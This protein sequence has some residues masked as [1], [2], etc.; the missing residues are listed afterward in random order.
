M[1]S[2]VPSNVNLL[3][4]CRSSRQGL[5]TVMTKTRDNHFVAQW[6]Q[7]GFIDAG[8]K[9]CYLTRR[10]IVRNGQNETIY[11]KKWR[12]PAQQFY[13]RDLYSTFF[14]GEVNDDIEQK[15]SGPIDDSGSKAIRAFSKNDQSQW[16]YNFE[17]FLH[18]WM[19]KNCERRKVW[20]GLKANALN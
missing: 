6:H 10:D 5:P 17:G 13:R 1:A 14:G 19:L 4:A 16:H 12:A 3:G 18:I 8:E 9:L 11:S 2:A 7:K 20:I 15:L